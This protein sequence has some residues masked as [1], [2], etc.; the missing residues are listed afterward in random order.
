[1]TTKSR[2]VLSDVVRHEYEQGFC[3]ERETL[4]AGNALQVGEPVGKITAAGADKGKVVPWNPAASDGSQDVYGIAIA[5]TL[6]P[7]EADNDLCGVIVRGPAIIT[8]GEI[9]GAFSS[10]SASVKAAFAATLEGKSILVR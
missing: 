5:D 6:A 1:M 2:R 4:K 10:A 3:R 9:P 7:A 8:T